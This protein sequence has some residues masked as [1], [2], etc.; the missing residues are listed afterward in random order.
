MGIVVCFLLYTGSLSAQADME[1][2]KRKISGPTNTR[3]IFEKLKKTMGGKYA[4][5]SGCI[6]SR[7]IFSAKGMSYQADHCAD[8]VIENGTWALTKIS[9]ENFTLKLDN[10]YLVDFYTKKLNKKDRLYMRLKLQGQTMQEP[11]LE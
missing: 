2:M 6:Y 11:S 7:I 1:N 10:I 3:W 9:D 4:I 5:S 8:K